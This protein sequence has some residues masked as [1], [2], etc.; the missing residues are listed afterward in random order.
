MARPQTQHSGQV[1]EEQL[2]VYTVSRITRDVRA[3]LEAAFETVWVE[4]E[5]SNFVRA[6]SGHSYFVLKDDKAQIKCVLFRGQRAGMK[7]NPEDGDQ[8]LLLGRVTVYEAR[9]EY[10]IIVEAME[11]KGLGALQKAFE[12]L[13]EKL[14]KEGLFDEDRKK[15]LPEIP[16]KVGIV[17]SPSGAA[18]RDL[19][20]VIHRR[21]PKT[22][23]LLAPVKVQGEGAAEEI[24]RSIRDLN[25]RN[26]IDVIIVGRG[27]GSIEDLW[28]F[29]E[30]VVARAM[31]ASKIPVVS[32][33][34][35]EVDF[36]ISDFV[37]DLRA[38]TPSAAAELVV[39][40]LSELI[41]DLQYL[42][43]QMIERMEEDIEDY[44]ERLKAL[45]DRRF[46]REPRQ[47][48]EGPAQR[49]DELAQRLLRG[50]DQ[51]VLVKRGA[52]G[53]MVHR[54]F[55]A[56]PQKQIQ[57]LSEREADLVARMVRRMQ[58]QIDLKK[59][60]LSGAAKHL[61]ALSPLSILDRGYSITTLKKTGKAVKSSKQVKKG[62][63]VSIRL[64]KGRLDAT[65]D[66]IME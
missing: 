66:D 49:L 7:F 63:G 64:A 35:H 19:L 60:K 57:R 32:A 34:G 5:I 43:H 9:G 45:I 24:A 21:N 62:D 50:L 54:L 40:K 38:P 65:V 13:K 30:E 3:I 14:A 46:F 22:S 61:D 41:Q 17:T 51:W 33:V 59:Q 53:Q 47:I 26:D 39:P 12:Q 6:A 15:S 23:V 4:G 37:A 8:V 55:Q 25:K 29:N 18:I 56:T 58:S 10:Q 28:A 2:Q 36:T 48:L 44:R 31:A 52:V 42:T 1:P 16:W 27:G 20:N 11:P